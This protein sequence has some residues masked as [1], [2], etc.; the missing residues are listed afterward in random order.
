[1]MRLHEKMIGVAEDLLR[2]STSLTEDL[3]RLAAE[4]L[5]A[6]IRVNQ[7]IFHCLSEVLSILKRFQGSDAIYLT[8]LMT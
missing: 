6:H 7:R 1:M 3:Q 8:R 5:G 2:K 4:A